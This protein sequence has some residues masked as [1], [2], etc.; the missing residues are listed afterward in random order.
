MDRGTRRRLS[1]LTIALIVVL[2]LSVIAARWQWN[3]H[4]ERDAMNAAIVASEQAPPMPWQRLLGQGYREAVDWRRVT[5]RGQWLPAEQV[6]VRKQVVDGEVGFTV[7]TPFQDADG[8]LLY[9]MRGWVAPS[10]LGSLPPAP[11]GPQAITLRVRPVEGAG[12]LGASDLP[13][14]QLNRIDPALLAKGRAHVEALFEL[15]NPM[16][17]GLVALPWP[18]LTSGPHLSYF[19]QWI[20]IGLTAII[21]YVRV[22]RSE[23]RMDRDSAVGTD[24][25]GQNS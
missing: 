13:S 24:V 19:V 23:L 16:P 20:L 5:A 14:G 3:R 11:A 7:M 18:E 22:F 8:R 15:L 17:A 25:A 21:V 10:S 6:L 2:P 4:L 12:P 1:S 9:V